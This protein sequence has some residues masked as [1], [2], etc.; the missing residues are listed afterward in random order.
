MKRDYTIKFIR[1]LLENYS[2]LEQGQWYESEDGEKRRASKYRAPFEAAMIA[3]SDIDKAIDSLGRRE[4]LFITDLYIEGYPL[5]ELEYRFPNAMRLE[6]KAIRDMANYLNGE[7]V[8]RRWC[9][10]NGLVDSMGR[11][12]LPENLPFEIKQYTIDICLN[13]CVTKKC[14]E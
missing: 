14:P 3:K 4:K 13:Y 8:L 5:K 12:L 1:T 6:Q 9:R 2:C 7:C 10:E 11:I